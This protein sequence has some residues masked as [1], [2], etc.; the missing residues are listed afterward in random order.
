MLEVQE[1]NARANTTEKAGSG[2]V[3]AATCGPAATAI[4]AAAS[5]PQEPDFVRI[6]EV[7]MV[8]SE[9][10]QWLGTLWGDRA[11]VVQ[12]EVY[13]CAVC[14]EPARGFHF[15][16]FTCEGCKSSLEKASRKRAPQTT[17]ENPTLNA[18]ERASEEIQR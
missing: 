15:G 7:L 12:Q 2:P 1:D 16:A 8:I 18:L 5:G 17:V 3:N 4:A 6:L 11:A 13:S 9:V 14:G 10:R